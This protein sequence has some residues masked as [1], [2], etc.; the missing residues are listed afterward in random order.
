MKVASR[1]S[2]LSSSSCQVSGSGGGSS[3]SLLRV[4][5][6]SSTTVREMWYG[7]ETKDP[8]EEQGEDE[9]EGSLEDGDDI[10]PW[11]LPCST[12]IALMIVGVCCSC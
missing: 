9:A 5:A 7:Q 4:L 8:D 6:S 1:D 12:F 11:M 3:E 2:L 10:D